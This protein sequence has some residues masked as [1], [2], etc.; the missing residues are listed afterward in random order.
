MAITEL[1]KASD[2]LAF[3]RLSH[4]QIAILDIDI[5]TAQLI[6]RVLG[7]IGITRT[8]L[9]RDSNDM[10]SILKEHPIDILIAE[11]DSRPDTGIDLTRRLRSPDSNNRMLPIILTTSRTTTSDY[12]LAIDAGVNEIVVKPFNVRKMLNTILRIINEP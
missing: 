7:N 8:H 1:T 10:V 5:Y 12:R 11:W 9:S 6:R 3:A 2:A 4:L